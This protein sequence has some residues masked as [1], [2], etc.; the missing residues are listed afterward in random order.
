MLNPIF[1]KATDLNDAWHQA[2][3][4]I[5][6]NG[7][8]FKIDAGSYAGEER[9]E[10]DYITIQITHP[11]TRPLEPQLPEHLGIPNPVEPGYILGDSPDFKGR[12]YIE[13]LM[14]GV[15][16]E[17]EDYTYGERLVAA[18]SY[19]ECKIATCSVGYYAYYFNQIEKIIEVYKEKGYRNNQMVL[20]IAQP[21]DLLLTDPPCLRAID[22]RVQDGKLHF[23][24]YFRSWDLWG[25]LPSNLAAIQ[26]LK[27][28]IAGELGVEDGEIIASSKGLHL[29]RYVWELA[30]LRRGV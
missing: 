9:L 4:S 15:R 28:Y 1:I 3:F 24:P 18:T 14:T 22:T 30:K 13:Y 27:E 5:L 21:S 16:E 2:V 6:D 23:F 10:F 7:R 11:G 12:P 8:R 25:G 29:Y 20:Q 17:G 26:I 19:S